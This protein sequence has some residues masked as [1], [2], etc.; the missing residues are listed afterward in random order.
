[1]RPDSTLLRVPQDGFSLLHFLI[2]VL[3]KK[4]P[5]PAASP[6]SAAET[7]ECNSSYSDRGQELV[8]DS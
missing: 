3:V 8:Q 5:Q 1:M 2:L 7:D 4:T 6:S